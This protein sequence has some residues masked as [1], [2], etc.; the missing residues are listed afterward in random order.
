MDC[1][2]FII[3]SSKRWTLIHLESLILLTKVSVW[4]G[5]CWSR[6]PRILSSLTFG[7]ESATSQK[8]FKQKACSKR[9]GNQNFTWLIQCFTTF[10]YI[11]RKRS[12]EKKWSKERFVSTVGE[13][14]A[15][16]RLGNGQISSSLSLDQQAKPH[17]S[18]GH[19]HQQWSGRWWESWWWGS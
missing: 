10:T 13:L 16:M 3:M 6:L 5:T 17:R 19:L 11:Q 18:Q 2:L 15:Q 1:L 9:I 14:S 4:K 12:Q 7:E 8:S